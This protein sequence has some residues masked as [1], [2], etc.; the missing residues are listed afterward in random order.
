MMHTFEVD[1]VWSQKAVD[2]RFQS[3]NEQPDQ[4]FMQPQDCMDCGVPGNA[5]MQVRPAQSAR[6]CVPLKNS[7]RLPGR[8]GLGACTALIP[9]DAFSVSQ[10]VR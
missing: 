7:K 8:N 4:Q 10:F 3:L 6:V 2:A 5:A 1:V 9:A